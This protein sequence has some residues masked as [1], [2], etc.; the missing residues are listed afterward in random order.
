[1]FNR[2]TDEQAEL[3]AVAESHAIN[4]QIFIICDDEQLEPMQSSQEV[5]QGAVSKNA[6]PA[7][8]VLVPVSRVAETLA[9][10]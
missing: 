4:Y 5:P 7:D 9:A 10:L 2:F 3:V 8:A 6:V 1:M